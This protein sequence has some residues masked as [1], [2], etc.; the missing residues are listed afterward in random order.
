MSWFKEAKDFSD[1]NVVNDKIRYLQEIR[2]IILSNSKIVFQS[3]KT[4]KDSS[5]S[6]ISSSK[7]SSYPS[8][9]EVLIQ[10]DALVLDSP[11]RFGGLCAEAV[12]KIDQ[13]VYALKEERKVL[14][15]GTEKIK[16]KKG[17]F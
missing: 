11:W 1:R 15:Y 16:Y 6:M 14:T 12:D 5:Y 4:V 8:L 13:L 17:L 3:G 7:I 2:N 10:A 9:H